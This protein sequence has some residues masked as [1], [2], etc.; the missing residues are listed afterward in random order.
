MSENVLIASKVD[1]KKQA[2]INEILRNK[3][4][5]VRFLQESTN[6]ERRKI[7]AEAD[8]ILTFNPVR[9]LEKEEFDLLN[10]V[11]FIQLFSAGADH[12]PFQDIPEHIEMAS[13]TGAYGVPIAEH[14]LAMTLAL[15]KRLFEEHE[16]MK[17]GEFN[18]FNKVNKSI[19]D[20]TVGILGFGGIGKA[21]ARL[22]RS[23]GSKIFAMNTSGKSDEPTD[24]IG[25]L[26]DLKYMLESSD[27]VIL[28]MPL[29]NKTRGL[30]G[31]K[32]LSWMKE[33]A[34]L[35]NVARGEIIKQK[36]LYEHLRNHPDFKAGLES[37]W[38]EPLRHG[39]F[40]LDYPFLDLPN[41]LA[42]PHNSS[43]VPGIMDH[44]IAEAARNIK[45]FINGEP[46][47]GRIDRKDYMQE[48]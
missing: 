36:D 37:W 20:S 32:Q 48:K 30:L 40:K 33:D 24:F 43:I 42:S 8:I 31:E 46:I 2:I 15:A 28:S 12:I 26:N 13:N 39:A 18:Q 41:V 47:K 23:F 11:R 17:K 45:K 25:T 29:T 5:T 6:K 44:G 34:I 3:N 4:V 38:V 27:I 14:V 19:K 7:L 10:N 21:T 22:F 16:N 1:D 9:D 35:I